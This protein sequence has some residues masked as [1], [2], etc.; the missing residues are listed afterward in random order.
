M[1]KKIFLL[2]MILCISF[3]A[4][5]VSAYPASTTWIFNKNYVDVEAYH[6][7]DSQCA[8]VTGPFVSKNTGAAYSTSVNYD[9][10]ETC[11]STHYTAHYFYKECFIPME[12]YVWS[13]CDLSVSNS[14]NFYKKADCKSSIVSVDIPSEA[15]IGSPVQITAN[16]KSAFKEG[17]NPPEYVPPARKDIFYSSEVSVTLTVKKD[18]ATIHTQTK[19]LN[20]Y[21]EGA[22]D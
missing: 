17:V 18:G 22:K 4:I 10:P 19:S 20:I 6:C 16:V 8:S 7:M 3:A 2:S 12:F 14:V 9:V 5:V 21:R 13:T 11:E 1:K 15:S